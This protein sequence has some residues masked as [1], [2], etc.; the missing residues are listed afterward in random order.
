MILHLKEEPGK[1]RFEVNESKCGILL[2]GGGDEG[3]CQMLGFILSTR[4]LCSGN[5][6]LVR[7]PH[8]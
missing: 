2:P 6:A 3:I 8:G 4:Q 7:P 1:G 5:V